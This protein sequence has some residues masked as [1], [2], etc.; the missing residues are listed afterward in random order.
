MSQEN[1]EIVRRLYKAWSEDDLEAFLATV[2]PRIEFRTS[3]AFPDFAPEYLGH[4]GMRRLWRE[5]RAPWEWFR[6]E[7][8]NFVEAEDRAATAVRFLACGRGSGVETNLLLGHALKFSEGQIVRI[9]AVR[10]F[11]EALEAAGLSE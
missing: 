8:E 3:G 9:V 7:L 4:E 2:H 5:M 10:T 11:E 1:V 6:I